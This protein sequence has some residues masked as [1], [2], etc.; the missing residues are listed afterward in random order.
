MSAPSIDVEG[1]VLINVSSNTPI[2]GRHGLLYNVVHESDE[3]AATPLTADEDGGY[4]RADVF[5]PGKHVQMC[6]KLSI[7]GG[8]VWKVPVQ[9]NEMSFEGVYKANQPLDPSECSAL[10]KAAHARLRK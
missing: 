6:S 7:D 8:K 10:A 4:V 9:D 2:Y 1:C 3:G 5:M